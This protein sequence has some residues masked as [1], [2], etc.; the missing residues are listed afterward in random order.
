MRS[1]E[2]VQ[3]FRQSTPY[4]TAH[5]NKT[6]V[7]ML[8]GNTTSSPNFSN[9]IDDI[10]LLHSLGIKLV[11]VFGARKQINDALAEAHIAERYHKNIRVTDPQTLHLVKQV[12][13][14]L[15]FDITARL[16]LRMNNITHNGVPNVVSGNFVIAQPLG[17]DDGVDYQLSGK[18]RKID[19]EGIKQQLERNAIVVISP[20]GVSVTGE[21]FNLAFEEL[22]AQIAIKLKAEK[23]I[24]FCEKQ[25]IIDKNQQ[26][27]ADLTLL[28]AEEHLHQLIA[29][30]AYHSSE[31][32]FLQ[33]ALEACRNGVKRA[34]LL[35][36]LED[37]SLLQELFSR[38]G[39]GTQISLESSEIVRI[40]NIKDIPNLLALIHPLEQQGILVKRSREQLEMEI[41]HYT[42][43]DRDGVI[44]ACAALN[45]YFEEKMAEMACVA[46]HPDYRN[47]SRGDILLSHIQKRAI[48]LGIKKL[49]VL[50]TRTVHW[51]QERG[52]EI[53]N[54]EDLPQEKREKYN[55]QRRSKI[56]IQPLEEE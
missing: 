48:A 23:V 49:F 1:T 12:V 56:L 26:V 32:R 45:P 47:S 3:W 25:G 16:S 6:F 54:V 52:F 29:K 22:A 28:A 35:S 37:G 21:T 53:A 33:T 43:I 30:D 42:I 50:T 51:F 19:S 7:I 31:A 13:G 39:I 20:I 44:I 40:A 46:V 9:I 27:I 38:D 14:S 15:Q 17:V 2:L 55:Y 11:I 36:Y 18:V 34:H 5:R 8:D 4:V 24:G 41:D 10:S